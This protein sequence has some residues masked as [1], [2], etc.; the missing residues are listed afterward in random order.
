MKTNKLIYHIYKGASMLLQNYLLPTLDKNQH[1]LIKRIGNRGYFEPISKSL[2]LDSI[3]YG[4]HKKIRLFYK[5]DVLLYY[6]LS[7][8]KLVNS[9]IMH[10][11]YEVLKMQLPSYN[12][13]TLLFNLFTD[14]NY[15]NN[16]KLSKDWNLTRQYTNKIKLRKQN[17]SE[18]LKVKIANI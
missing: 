6:L 3:I 10:A 8:E 14:L 18:N 7:D 15:V 2:L 17:I 9:T 11:Y 12:H 5:D 1:P 16:C 13:K 4:M